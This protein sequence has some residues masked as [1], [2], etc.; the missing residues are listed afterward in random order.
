MGRFI[1]KICGKEFD[2][3]GNGVYCPGPHF[4]PCP[5]CGKPVEFHRLSEPIKCC[6]KECTDILSA[7]SK[8]NRPQRV[9][10]E[11]GNLFT[12]VQASQIYC[13]GPHITHCEV[14]GKEISYTCSPKEKPRHCSQECINVAH[15]CTVM[16]RYGV[17]NVSHLDEV[18]DKISASN[19]SPESQAK[20]KATCLSRY[21]VDNVSKDS[22]IRARLSSIMR[23]EIYLARRH[24]TCREQYGCDS[25]MQNEA[26][27]EKQRATFRL[28]YNREGR[29]YQPSDYAALMTDPK[30]CEAYLQFK[31]DPAHYIQLH[32]SDKPS[33]YQL[34]IDLGVTST[35][36]YEILIAHNCQHMI[37]RYHSSMEQEVCDYI[38]TLLPNADIR[39]NDRTVIAPKELDIYLPEYYVGFECNPTFTH[40]SSF[41]DGWGS[42]P[43]AI[44]YHQEKSVAASKQDVFLFHIFGYEWNLRKDII[45]SMIANLLGVSARKV[46]ARNCYVCEISPTECRQFLKSNHRQG[47]VN[48]RIRLGLRIKSTDELVSVMT[49]DYLR[50]T[51]GKDLKSKTASWELSRFCSLLN[52]NVVGG[53][54]KLFSYFVKTYNPSQVVSFSDVAHTRGRLY[55]VLGFEKVYVTSPS[56]VWAAL[57]DTKYYHRVSCQKRNLQKLFHDDTIDVGHQTER[58]IMEAHR[59]AQVYDS[60]VI[61]WVLRR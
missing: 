60:G 23:S 22:D 29:Q 2:R 35:P 58:Q 9:C 5:V 20:R 14:C 12:P 40:N 28:H 11:C 46:S 34:C 13:K 8:M 16:D 57:D 59:F 4:R 27:K 44:T 25:P 3:V 21:G 54:G 30:K 53:A 26:V 38:R 24:Q 48:A 31:E 36:I 43:K 37:A 39:Q 6:S 17:D 52:C 42:P 41:S 33:A 45:K 47:S 15:Q 49:F 55:E 10:A 19:S 18:R 51:M 56:Y 7:R 61:K 1:C 50:A 32:Y